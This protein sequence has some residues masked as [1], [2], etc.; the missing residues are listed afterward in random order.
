MNNLKLNI[1]NWCLKHLF[2]AITDKDIMRWNGKNFVMDDKTLIDSDTYDIISGADAIK[3]SYVWQLI[4]KDMKNVS[5]KMLYEKSKTVDDMIFGKA[6]LY[7]I[8]VIENKLDN[9]SKIKTKK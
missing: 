8:D 5:N 7:T 3:R 2:N 1:L 6:C 4:V 9:L